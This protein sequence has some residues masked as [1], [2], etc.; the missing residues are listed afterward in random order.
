MYRALLAAVSLESQHKCIHKFL[1]D[2]DDADDDAN[3]DEDASVS[4]CFRTEFT[5]DMFRSITATCFLFLSFTQGWFGIKLHHLNDWQQLGMIATQ[6]ENLTYLNVFLCLSF[7]S[8]IIYQVMAIFWDFRF[9][10]IPL[11]GSKDVQF[12]S[13]LM[14]ILWDY[15]P[16]VLLLLYVVSPSLQGGIF[17]PRARSGSRTFSIDESDPYGR[18]RDR[19]DTGFTSDGGEGTGGRLIS[20]GDDGGEESMWAYMQRVARNF[21][22]LVAGRGGSSQES[23]EVGGVNV[24]RLLLF[25]DNF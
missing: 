5:G 10:N 23:D 17:A 13:F 21:Q 8:R 16:T 4:S 9:A 14:I 2:S 3:E 6:K 1:S 22:A 7:I 19:S 25:L 11:N 15:L 18:G 24:S 12:M 20:G